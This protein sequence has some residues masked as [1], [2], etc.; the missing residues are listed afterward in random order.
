VSTRTNTLVFDFDGTISLGHGP[1]LAYANGVAAS[2]PADRADSLLH[3]LTAGL[4]AHPSG[5]VPGTDAI[6]GYAL[7]R[8]LA[9]SRG[10]DETQLSDA[11]LS[12][13]ERL[14]TPDAQINAPNGLV[15]F[16][17]EARRSAHLILATNA[18]DI[19]IPEALDVLGI[20]ELFD[21]VHTSVGKPDGLHT[22]LDRWLPV[23]RV[24][25]IGDVWANDL[26]PA[27]RR[28]ATTALVASADD[29]P[30]VTPDFR[31]THL[32]ELYPAILDWLGI[33]VD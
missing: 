25:A 30:E 32:D 19:R 20:S 10:A 7:V 31:A 33:G 11:Y 26:E 16:L 17:A 9:L 28:G 4:A 14:A 24:L 27:Q 23:G 29:A 2:L 13:R 15:A 21:E 1:V 22:I 5:R 6:D 12:S 8:E 18:P 3:E